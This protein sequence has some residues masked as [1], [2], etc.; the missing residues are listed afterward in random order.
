MIIDKKKSMFIWLCALS[1]ICYVGAGI[2]GNIR[3]KLLSTALPYEP[4]LHQWKF[5]EVDFPEYNFW[6]LEFF[7]HTDSL[8]LSINTGSSSPA[9]LSLQ[10]DSLPKV[11]QWEF[12][13]EVNGTLTSGNYVRLYLSSDQKD[14]R[15]NNQNYHIQI[16]GSSGSHYYK[17]Y[18]QVRARRSLLFT[19]APIENHASM[20]K[21]KIIINRR[22]TGAWSIR[23]EEFGRDSALQILPDDGSV[24]DQ[25]VPISAYLGIW[26][27]FT[28][29]RRK[30]FRIHSIA[31]TEKDNN[32]TSP[33]PGN[34]DP[35]EFQD[36]IINEI[37]A[38]PKG[39]EH[40]PDLE[41]IELYNR[42][43]DSI[44]LKGWEYSSTST[45]SKIEN[46]WIAPY[47]FLILCR[48]TDTATFKRFG[49]AHGLSRW[50]TLTNT[51]TTLTLKSPSGKL[52][53]SVSYT[54]RW[55]SN[56][57]SRLGGWSLE[58]IFLK[59][60]CALTNEWL[61]SDDI[62]G[63]TPGRSNSVEVTDTPRA[64]LLDFKISDTGIILLT[65]NRQMNTETRA[66]KSTLYNS[67]TKNLVV[68]QTSWETS[69]VLKISTREPFAKSAGF[70]L[71]IRDLETCNGE[72]ASADISFFVPDRLEANGILISEILF[73]PRPGGDDFVEI[74]NPTNKTFDLSN[75]SLGT[76]NT[77]NK[78]V[79]TTSIANVP[80]YIKPGE[81]KVLTTDPGSLLE[82]YPKAIRNTFIKMDKFPPFPNMEGTVVL[83]NHTASPPF[84]VDSIYYHHK[85]HSAGI[86]NPKGVSLERI[87]LEK[88]RFELTS[89]PALDGGATPGYRKLFDGKMTENFIE[90]KSRILIQNGDIHE[91]KIILEYQFSQ[92]AVTAD[93][94][95]INFLG[96]PVKRLI[97]HQSITATGQIT[98]DGRT[99][100]GN[101]APPGIY[102]VQCN[103]YNE[104]GWKFVSKKTC[105][106]MRKN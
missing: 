7:Q 21:A 79:N 69:H 41:Y 16:D 63:G 90:Q 34:P 59:D 4:S 47:T 106:L 40:W 68:H 1:A 14:F 13:I 103:F 46:V 78:W 3:Q 53:D 93:V 44:S 74:Y 100:N 48:D 35:Y 102:T 43:P 85:M 8:G 61:S 5:K 91:N 80:V 72:P 36:V 57:L 77:Q 18:K 92:P 96:I 98:W 22:T 49:E 6:G 52:I 45:R 32:D 11:V 25:S 104:M 42:Y 83:I 54:D 71:E 58:R 2:P 86:K 75:L 88:R 31:V 81:F 10:F 73:E 29:T 84:L 37:M 60:P 24:S 51:G 65:F 67:D 105:I 28:S 62:M 82:V 94:T 20:F 70:N 89:G 55:Y 66:F 33:E 12:E 17:F 15:E 64:V 95:V 26:C 87:H 38:N 23:T 50:P 101:I 30:D 19:S 56:A 27:S 39:N 9:A 97:Q 76:V 99:D